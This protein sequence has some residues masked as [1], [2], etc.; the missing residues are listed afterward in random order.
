MGSGDKYKGLFLIGFGILTFAVL[1]IDPPERW[2][3]PY[4][5][6]DLPRHTL[7]YA[8]PEAV[9]I[10]SLGLDAA[11]EARATAAL[12]GTSYHAA[13]AEGPEGRQGQWSGAHTPELARSHA[14]AACG[15]EC[16][17]LAERRPLQSI[18]TPEGDTLILSTGM[19]RRIGERWPYV[20]GRHAL[21][22][23]G[24]GAWG[25]GHSGGRMNEFSRAVYR[26]V[27]E[28]EARRA[29][30]A[31]PEGAMSPPC[32][33]MSLRDAEIVDIRP[34]PERYPAPYEVALSRL[35]VLSE[36]GLRLV[37]GEA[38]PLPGAFR[39]RLPVEL[40]GARASNGEGARG[41]VRAGGW[42]EA[43]AELALALCEAERRFG[44]PPC[45][46]VAQRMPPR[47]LPEG[48]LGVP[49]DLMEAFLAWERHG[50]A[51]AFAIS[52]LGVWGWSYNLETL[53]EARQRAADW[54][55]YY[56]RRGNRP[57]TLRRAFIE[58]PPCRIVAERGP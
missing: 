15:A 28:C 40:Y 41:M 8:G 14:L 11:A 47:P 23:G 5:R 43:G 27:A 33:A 1:I 7:V 48:T 18:E 25:T 50:G 37:D 52:A 49:P 16:R 29:A 34:V 21:A 58:Q 45:T 17:V 57:F 46:L 42:P 2:P 32:Q 3:A 6:E 26:A 4:P 38:T 30:E 9:T 35:A 19:A 53:E 36:E 56:A 54:C 44:D 55:S 20:S 22:I 13:Y 39:N 10:T 24:A 51:G 31:A 12:E